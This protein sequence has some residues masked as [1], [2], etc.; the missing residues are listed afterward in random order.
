MIVIAEECVLAPFAGFPQAENKKPAIAT[1]KAGKL[2]V[3]L[4]F[5]AKELVFCITYLELRSL[6]L[7]DVKISA[8][9][10]AYLFDRS[11]G[12]IDIG[13]FFCP[14]LIYQLLNFC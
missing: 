14:Q 10:P 11:S 6:F 5:V 8:G 13:V 3:D 1:N 2:A 9:N 12:K 7:G 4:N